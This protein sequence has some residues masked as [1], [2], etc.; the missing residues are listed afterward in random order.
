MI[1]WTRNTTIQLIINLL[2]V[3]IYFRPILLCKGGGYIYLGHYHSSKF[4]QLIVY[5]IPFT[6]VDSFIASFMS[7]ELL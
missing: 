6:V 2:N 7:V 5:D 4:K 3:G 1:A